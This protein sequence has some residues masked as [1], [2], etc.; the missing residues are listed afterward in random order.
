M[1]KK[2]STPKKRLQK[3]SGSS[4]R[5]QYTVVLEE[6]RSDFRIFGEALAGLDSKLTKRLDT[7][8]EMIGEIMTDLAEIKYNMRQKVDL[9]QFARLEKRVVRLERKVRR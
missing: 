1:R 5:D 2:K 7:H 4:E 6:L 3:K 9:S 8:Q